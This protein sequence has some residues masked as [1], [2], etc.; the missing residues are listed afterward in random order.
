MPIHQPAEGQ[1]AKRN[2]YKKND[3]MNDQADHGFVS[4]RTPA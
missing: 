1:S 2:A 4:H 3:Q